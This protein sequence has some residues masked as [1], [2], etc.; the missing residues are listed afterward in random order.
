MFL[1]AAVLGIFLST[2]DIAAHTIFLGDEKLASRDLGMVYL[3]SGALG[4]LIFAIFS[5]AYKRLSAKSFN[6]INLFIIL[7][8]I[9]LYIYFRLFDPNVWSS[10]F[11]LVV[12]FP[13]NL[14]A[15][16][17]FWRYLR[18]LLHPGQSRRLFPFIELGF[19]LGIIGGGLSVVFLLT[20]FDYEI[21]P[22][23]SIIALITLFII[24]FPANQVHRS[25]QIFN[26]RK[27]KFVPV[28][29]AILLIFSTKYT[30]FLFFMALIAS[31]VGFLI[32]FGFISIARQS[33]SSVEGMSKFYGLFIGVM[34]LFILFI[35]RFLVRKILYS[36]DS[37]YSLI[38]FPFAMFILLLPTIAV[39][40][41]FSNLTAIDRF[42]FL[43]I[44]IGMN[45]VVFETMLYVIQTPS[46]RTLYRT[47]DIRF[48]QII[49]PRIEGTVVMLGMLLAGGIIIG[50]MN[51]KI[52]PVRGAVIA[53]LVLIPLWFYFTIKLIKAYK[54]AL[55]ETYRKLRIS[56][57][58]ELKSSSYNEKI[59]EILVGE[60]PGKVI[61]AMR[62]SERIEPLEYEK[63]LQR[64]LAHPN[65]EIQNYVLRCI[66]KE[67]MIELLPELKKIVP[68]SK[69]NKEL[70]ARIIYEF[71]EKK[72]SFEK[73]HDIESLVNSRKIQDRLLAAE[74]IGTRKDATYTSALINLTREFEPDVKIAAVKAMARMS[75]ADHSYILIEF[76]NYPEYH[77]YAFEALVEI[78]EPSLEYLERLFLNP[79]IDESILSSVVRIY[80]KVGTAK[81]IDLLLGKLENQSRRVTREAIFALHEANFQASSLNVHRI[82][83]NVVR[84][85]HTLGWNFLIITSLPEK[86]KYFPLR[87]A[88][89]R[90]I[91][92]DYDLLYDLL[93]LAYNARTLREIR[94]L[95]EKG[96][97]PDI[98]HAIEMLD[99]FVFEDIKPVLLPI[100]E[101]I[102]NEDRVKRL[103][104]Y[105]PIE[106]MKEHE[107]ITFILTRDYNLLSIYPRVCAMELA[108]KM[109]DFQVSQE[110]IANMFHPNRLLRE[111]AAVVVH[112]IDTDL[113]QNVMQRLDVNIQHE[114]I[115]T[116]SAISSQDRLLLIDKF[117]IIR[118]IEKFVD[119]SED[120]QIAMAQSFMERKFKAG[121]YIDLK[122]HAM[123]YALFIAIDG[124][125]EFNNQQVVRI[126]NNKYQVFYS[127]MLVN[128]GIENI[129]FV[130][131]TTLLCIDDHIIQMLLFDYSEIAN[132]MLSCIEEFKLAG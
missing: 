119:L 60:D 126:Q 48:L 121:Q 104:Y 107:M 30:L 24:Q 92:M 2:F 76:L 44:L 71:G 78:G 66:E 54:K 18:N 55:Q 9:S 5:Q 39:F 74:I 131:D 46:L 25:Q 53:A 29:S 14:L 32:H 51:I 40:I 37:P 69:E 77:A 70:L 116:L 13:V 41:I 3:F 129:T 31:A 61:N 83:N 20:Q 64:M 130:R 33:F 113:F 85:I 111:V 122:K 27:E 88:F 19:I 16:L 57:T 62:L 118:D 87:M 84:V 115:D 96:S 98:S 124:E 73:G 103:Q 10:F 128:Y 117:N 6:F 65:S 43:F 132:C 93:S 58:H 94:E 59:R 75:D 23:L 101:N 120:L 4:V 36:Y 17:N 79:N 125:W 11:G 50:L 26:H 123:D 35:S 127:N 49:I 112:Q 34:Y 89:S 8:T 22:L 90:E 105:F 7:S 100:L 82:L 28:K 109:E 42:T 86:E 12:M 114:I 67:S 80:G 97:Q 102:S 15:I 56:R 68:S 47:L 63:S 91:E 99:H 72:D 110:L 95:I 81:A 52:S 45:K 21:I 106:T 1:S 108:M 38:L